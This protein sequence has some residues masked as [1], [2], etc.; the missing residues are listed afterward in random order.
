M[1]KIKKIYK[2]KGKLLEIGCGSGALL[3]YF[4]KSMRVFGVDYSRELLNIAKKSNSI[5]KFL[6]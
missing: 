2:K 5:R 6:F 4:S 1:K 3:K